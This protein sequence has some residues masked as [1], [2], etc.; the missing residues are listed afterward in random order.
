MRFG[1]T[2]QASNIFEMVIPILHAFLIKLFS[3]IGIPNMFFN[4]KK[5][6]IY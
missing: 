1:W 4:Q 2:I 3:L 5:P 6:T